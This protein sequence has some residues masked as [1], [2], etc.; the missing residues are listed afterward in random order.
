MIR[1][2]RG[3]EPRKLRE[4][5]KA[6]LNRVRP[7]HAAGTL[8]RD[9]LGNQYTT[10]INELWRAQFLMCC[11]CEMQQLQVWNDLE[12]FRPA[13]NA[14]RDSH[15]DSGYWWLAWSWQNLMFACR[16]CNRTAKNDWFP[17][18]VG[19]TPLQ[20]EE[21]PPGNESALLIDPGTE[22]P[23][24]HIQFRQESA[25]GR[26]L[27]HARNG[28]PRGKRTIEILQLATHP[29][30][31]ELYRNHVATYVEPEQAE[32]RQA[33][34]VG[35]ASEITRTWRR[36]TQKLLN[37]RRPFSGLSYDVLDQSF[38]CSERRQWNLV[39]HQPKP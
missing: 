26:W 19:S 25:T 30:F 33:I 11:Y 27:P 20:P 35:N 23:L 37:P 16:F 18:H 36:V 31:L 39:L 24:T 34:G 4:V 8:T 13:G 38:P 21:H 5:R 7:L 10:V 6:E 22:N 1:I 17:L 12:H 14:R 3:R 9:D 29:D 15:N 28:S 2:R 32:I